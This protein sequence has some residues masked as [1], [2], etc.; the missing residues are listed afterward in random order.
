MLLTTN[1]RDQYRETSWLSLD[2]ELIY[3]KDNEEEESGLG[4]GDRIT[5]AKLCLYA[6]AVFN[7][8]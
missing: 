5:L 6:I 7:L 3:L 4:G 8:Y 2:R 1:I